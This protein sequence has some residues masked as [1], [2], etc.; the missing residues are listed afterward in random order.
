[1]REKINV[2]GVQVDT[3]DM[4]EASDFLTDAI[5]KGIRKIS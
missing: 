2:L 4:N 3:F 1:M 5:E